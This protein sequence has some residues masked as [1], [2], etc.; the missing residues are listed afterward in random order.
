MQRQVNRLSF[1]AQ[2]GNYMLYANIAQANLKPKG[3][4]LARMPLMKILYKIGKDIA[5]FLQMWYLNTE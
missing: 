2:V 3:C 1:F 4:A 5:I